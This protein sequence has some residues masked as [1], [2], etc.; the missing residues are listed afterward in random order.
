MTL[1]LLMPTPCPALVATKDVQD[2]LEQMLGSRL[3]P[4]EGFF[5]PRSTSQ[6]AQVPS[7][8]MTVS[9]QGSACQYFSCDPKKQPPV[10]PTE[11]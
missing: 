5:K 4:E 7:M 3:F 9:N 6:A 1:S 10:P 8:G 2:P 11:S